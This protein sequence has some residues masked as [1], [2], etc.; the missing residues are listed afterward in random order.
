MANKLWKLL[1]SL[2][3]AVVVMILITL[4]MIVATVLE[5]VYDTQTAQYHIYQSP[6]F[7]ALYV[8]LGLNILCVA[9][10][11]WPWKKAHIPFLVA[12]LGILT[13][14]YGAWLTSFFGLDGSIQIKEN[15]TTSSVELTNSLLVVA[16][17]VQAQAKEMPWI[18][19][20]VKFKPFEYE[21]I[22]V[23]R[24][25]THAESEVKFLESREGFD[26]WKVQ[27]Q[28]GP[29]APPFLKQGTEAW[30]YRG[31]ANYRAIQLGGARLVL[32]DRNLKLPE[33]TSGAVF[34]SENKKLYAR[35]F[36]AGN[37]E[38]SK[39]VYPL[40]LDGS[41]QTPWKMD[42]KLTV[43]QYLQNARAEVT[44]T[45]TII[46]YGAQASPS[47]IEIEEISS[48]EKFWLGLGERVF[49]N[50]KGAKK[51]VGYFPKRVQL[52][53]GIK[54]NEF[55]IR[56][57]PGTFSASG[58]ESK[59]ELPETME[60]H[61]ISM[62]EPLQHR[63]YT[64]YQASYLEESP[65]PTVSIFSVNQDPGRFAKYIGSLLI[66]LGT[67]GLFVRKWSIKRSGA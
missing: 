30:L 15:E 44:Y 39:K 12:H 2:R 57:D 26:A 52:P 10:S 54:L 3:F 18:P 42:L 33:D 14:L 62:N 24:Y 43:L 67:A 32:G 6:W 65:R 9:L 21:G 63:Q 27:L 47:A 49:L 48:G 46:Q 51:M 20:H 56:R 13:L 50:S 61:T 29:K 16:E 36:S 58:F 17:G 35:F 55:I 19:P 59:I 34:F 11:R 1:T 40:K 25:L 41:L 23:T 4:S 5:S 7:F 38:V 37:L 8:C 22:R 31:D 64:I 66:V 53:F 45:P 28:G 60:K